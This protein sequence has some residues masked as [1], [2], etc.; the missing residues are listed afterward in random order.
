MAHT[1]PCSGIQLLSLIQK[2]HVKVLPRQSAFSR[3]PK[4]QVLIKSGCGSTII[5]IIAEK[6]LAVK[7]QL[8]DNLKKLILDVTVFQ[9]RT[10]GFENETSV[11]VAFSGALPL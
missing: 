11:K 7:A 9:F 2:A 3:R 5:N 8:A 10:F 4:P 1:Q 6:D